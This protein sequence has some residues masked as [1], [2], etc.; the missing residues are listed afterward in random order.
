MPI[1]IQLSRE[2]LFYE[3][4][5]N[6]LAYTV[7]VIH[8]YSKAAKLCIDEFGGLQPEPQLSVGI[9]LKLHTHL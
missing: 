4:L 6:K 2:Q 9:T 1:L 8:N 5:L 7:K 3:M